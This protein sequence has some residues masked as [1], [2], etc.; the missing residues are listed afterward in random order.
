MGCLSTAL[1]AALALATSP[2]SVA[3]AVL[4]AADVGDKLRVFA[5]PGDYKLEND[6]VTAVVRKRDG[7]LTELW[8][9]R[10]RL[11][12]NPQLG[13]TTDIDAIWQFHP[14][15][16][17]GKSVHPV[18]ASRV[19]MLADGIESEGIADTG[20]VKYRAVT[21]FRLDAQAA[22]LEM[23]ST[24]S[25]VGGAASGG[26]GLGD[27]FKWGNV[28]YHVSGVKRPRMSYEGP[29]EW[30]GRRSAGGDLVLRPVGKPRMHIKY[31]GR[32]RG[33]SGTITALQYR[34]GIAKDGSVTIRRQLAFEPLPI[35][36]KKAPAKVGKLVVNV[37]DEGGRPLPAKLTVDRV[38]RKRPLFEDD[39]DLLGT[40]RFLWTG[41]GA[42]EK[43][44]APGRYR[45]L[46]T[47]G[48][49][50]DAARQTV[51]V[52][53]GKTVTI[54]PQL[55]RVIDTP[56]W[57][58]SD[59][60]LHQAPSVDSDISIPHRIV[61]IA[62]E[63]VEFA[64]ATDHYVITD[65]AP[66]VKWMRERGVLS[67]KLQTM[68]GCEVSTLGNRFGHFNVFPLVKGRNV[69][70]FN[71]TVDELFADARKKSPT[72]V[73]QVNHPRW[74]PAIA[75]WSYFG[76]DDESGSMSRPGYNPNYDTVE[77]YNGDDARDLKL[78]RRV[79]LDWIHLLG[80]GQRYAATGSSDS[81]NLAFLDPGLPRTMVFHGVGNSD[82]TDVDAPAQKI[83]DAIKAGRSTVTSGPI[84]DASVAGRGPGQTARGVGKKAQLDVVVRA[85]PWIDVRSVE[86]IV[87]GR[88]K[89]QHYV[90]VPRRK[91][92]VRLDRTFAI[93]VDGP[94]FAIVVA[95]GERGLPNAS[96]DYTV[97]F[98]FTNPIWLEP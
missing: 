72:G 93:R 69:V 41:N 86:V 16:V 48:I 77:V 22:R 56:G 51:D 88:G 8:S 17:L 9:N 27:G 42:L 31:R 33:F 30:I 64:V 95:R 38:G 2:G 13:V 90:Q 44:L 1:G 57:I 39:G 45:V 87:G 36:P 79:M 3:P 53:A 62:A 18:M 25:V 68:A 84:I 92:V 78:V 65:L 20:A 81:H 50:R 12:T 71:T 15:V 49:E 82:A 34:G 32:I 6:L 70:S 24:F 26:V 7:W 91:K 21:T 29:A 43:D 75:Y 14:V 76:I 10:A 54:D 37:T 96:R 19:A 4:T 73:L 52:R 47:S 46:V 98:A 11:P 59:L 55:P 94:T 67:A 23:E 83:V 28:P 85:A 35:A 5:T 66:D 89:R 63:G 80:R 61:S 60:H 74:D 58:A 97:P 40:D